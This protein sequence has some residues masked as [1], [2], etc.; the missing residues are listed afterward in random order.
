MQPVWAMGGGGGGGGRRRGRG[1]GEGEG[2]SCCITMK[3]T[4]FRIGIVD[5][6]PNLTL[7]RTL[8]DSRATNVRISFDT[9]RGPDIMHYGIFIHGACDK[10]SMRLSMRSL[11]LQ[12]YL[13]H[14]ML[15]SVV[16]IA[17]WC[18]EP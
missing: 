15:M 17:S 2:T 12:V 3:L 14:N 1:E 10:L 11:P 16:C 13:E 6:P 8:A 4:P 7:T 18:L 9:P 5:P